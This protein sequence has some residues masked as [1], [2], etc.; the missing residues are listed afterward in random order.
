MMA[1]WLFEKCSTRDGYSQTYKNGIALAA[2]HAEPLWMS[3]PI[4]WTMRQFDPDGT[5]VREFL[6]ERRRALKSSKSFPCIQIVDQEQRPF[7]TDDSSLQ[8]R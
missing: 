8:P 6:E 4:F 3:R 2:D 1:L 7:K 5:A